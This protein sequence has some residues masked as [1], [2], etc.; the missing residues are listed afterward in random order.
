MINGSPIL[1]N[2]EIEDFRGHVPNLNGRKS[3]LLI[4]FP[5]GNLGSMVKNIVILP[6]KK[7]VINPLI[8]K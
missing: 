1:G 5:L 4:E 3:P 7:M 8:V 6:Q 2:H